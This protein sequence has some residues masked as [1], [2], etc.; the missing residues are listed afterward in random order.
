LCTDSES[1]AVVADEL[2]ASPLLTSP[3]AVERSQVFI[4][5]SSDSDDVAAQGASHLLARTGWR[6]VP[7]TAF[8]LDTGTAEAAT[9]RVLARAVE[10]LA[11]GELSDAL[12]CVRGYRSCSVWLLQEGSDETLTEQ[13]R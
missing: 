5:N 3:A 9:A 7:V 4:S 6:D 10:L 11:R 12:V 2:G 1:D 13:D 8:P